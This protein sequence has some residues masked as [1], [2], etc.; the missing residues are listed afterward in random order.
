MQDNEDLH[1]KPPSLFQ[2]ITNFGKELSKYIKE[3]APNVTPDQYT[4]RLTTCKKCPHL[5]K[6]SMRCGLCGCLLEH[7]AKW[8]TT[9]CPDKPGRWKK[10]IKKS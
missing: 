8:S 6:K 4:R 7:K 1:Q 3:G 5:I 9:D 2:M 10:I